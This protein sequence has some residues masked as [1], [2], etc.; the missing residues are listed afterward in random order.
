M[1]LSKI[2]ERIKAEALEKSKQIIEDGERQAEAEKHAIVARARQE[3]EALLEQ[4]TKD[5]EEQHNRLITLASLD[6]R[7]RRGEVR[8][9]AVDEAF[10]RALDEIGKMPDEQYVELLKQIVLEAAETGEEQIVLSARDRKR[11]GAKFT[12]EVNSALERVGKKA[13]MTL[14]DETR[15]MSGGVIL[16]SKD[17]EINCSFDTTLNLIRDDIEPEVAAILFSEPNRS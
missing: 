3:A 15:N 10:S 7:K 17:M 8:Q 16:I 6:L 11:V 5:A 2:I 14:S 13:A 1:A 4:G 12:D 9:A